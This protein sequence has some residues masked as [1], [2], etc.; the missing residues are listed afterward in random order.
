MMKADDDTFV[1]I[2]QVFKRLNDLPEETRTKVY[3]GVPTHC[4]MPGHAMVGRVF[5]D[6]AHKW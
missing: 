2:R 1:C 5:S 6:P 3:A 4:D